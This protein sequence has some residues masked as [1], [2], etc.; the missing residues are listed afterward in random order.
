[1]SELDNVKLHLVDD[2]N[3][4]CD[5]MQWLDSE[6]AS[7]AIAVDTE[8]TGLVIGVDQV[9]LVQ[10]G[11]FQHGWAIPWN[12]WSGLFEDIVR[13]YTGRF[14]MHN[15][16]FDYGM[17]KHMGIEVP[18]SQIDDSRVM[19]HILEPHMSTALKSQTA[20]H[21]DS[22]AAHAQGTLERAIGPRGAFDWATVPVTF[23]PYWQYAALDTVLT[24]HL[25]GRHGPLI[26]ESGFER[27]YDLENSVQW[28][29]AR[30][31]RYG[32]HI[33]VPYAEK[34]KRRFDQY[35]ESSAD[36]ITSNYG[37]KPGSN[38]AIVKILQDEGHTFDKKT[39]TGAIALDKEVLNGI[40]H[41]LARVV[42]RRRQMQKLSSTYLSH[43]ISEVDS[44]SNIHPSINTLGA[45]T[46]RMSM[47]SPNFQNLPRRSEDNPAA[48]V[49]R[50]CVIARP[51]HTLILCDFGQIEM[52]LLAALSNC[53]PM[54]NAF[55]NPDIDFFVN[56]ARQIFSD[57]TIGR[58]DPRRQITKNGG[59]ATIYGAGI[60]KFA[61]T[62]GVS[63]QEA[64]NF[65][66]HWNAH[67]PQV[68]KFQD[69]V[70]SLAWSRQ[71]ESG[72]PYACSPITG[73]HF[74]ADTNKV[75]ALVNYLIQG[76]AAEIF[77]TKLLQLDA[78][79]LGPWMM[80]PVHD[81]IIL[82]V[83]NENVPDVVHTLKGI[84]NDET[85]LSVPIT[86]TIAHGQKW[87]MKVDFDV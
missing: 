79:G 58:K 12:R 18:T 41:P 9:R 87:G 28:V 25:E 19:S 47:S 42:L 59:Y 4:A 2:F 48:N 5:L 81:E 52:R 30:M 27:S 74:I 10:V 34:S 55:K 40:E 83:P 16:K 14:I 65:F 38:A 3:T 71:K 22:D 64:R 36:W 67:Y 17:L 73:R 44:D 45:R 15:A 26:E 80:L 49:V 7:Y 82:D 21:V 39:A 6:D 72:A 11:G 43:F 68:K 29:I 1:M 51:G 69:N 62:A 86:A 70:S 13:R 54:I 56:L 63:E 85:M 75:Y 32:P 78:A 84:M 37:V 24:R 77:K 20:R 23:G 76:T 8:T 66:A 60:A 50:D 57:Q 35:V 31:E 61:Q 33:D 46:G 53:T